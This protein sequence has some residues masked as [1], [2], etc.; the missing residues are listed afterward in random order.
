MAAQVNISFISS[1]AKK[2][3]GY[4]LLQTVRYFPLGIDYTDQSKD[5]VW[6]YVISLETLDG[7]VVKDQIILYCSLDQFACPSETLY[8]SKDMIESQ[9]M[10]FFEILWI[11]IMSWQWHYETY[12]YKELVKLIKRMRIAH[13][14]LQSVSNQFHVIIL[15]LPM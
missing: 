12:A 7:L 15:S 11:Y 3:I 10:T 6:N 14:F 4:N 13:S 1:K 8:E 2:L 9:H 5:L